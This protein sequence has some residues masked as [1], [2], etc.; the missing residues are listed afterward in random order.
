[1]NFKELKLQIKEEQKTLAQKIRRSKIFRKPNNRHLM[2]EEESKFFLSNYDGEQ[3][4]S[5]WKIDQLSGEYRHVHIA[6]CQFFNNTPY[7]MIESPNTKNKPNSNK[8][9][10]L[11]KE[12]ETEISE[13][14]A[15]RNSA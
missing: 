8:V 2:T 7:G 3:Y 15:L 10:R 9:D 1:M 5:A 6:Y 11:K 4:F 14:E 12:W 13:S